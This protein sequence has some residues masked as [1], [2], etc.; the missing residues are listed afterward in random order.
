MKVTFKNRIYYPLLVCYFFVATVGNVVALRELLNC[1]DKQ[2]Q[3]TSEKKSRPIPDS[4]IWTIKTHILPAADSGLSIHIT[5]SNDVSLITKPSA[6]FVNV[7]I[8]LIYSS[9]EFLP[10]K[11]RDPPL[12]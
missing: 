12:S 9:L 1:G 10:S 7:E 4:P 6:I 11:P 8:A 5:P 2:Y 3:L